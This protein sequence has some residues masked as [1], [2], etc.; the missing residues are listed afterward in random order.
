MGEIKR[1]RS[2][3]RIYTKWDKSTKEVKVFSKKQKETEKQQNINLP[4]DE[5]NVNVSNMFAI[6]YNH[7]EFF[8]DFFNLTGDKAKLRSRIIMS[9]L[10][11]KRFYKALHENFHKYN[12]KYE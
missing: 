9:P 2:G 12:K 7:G 8:L 4:E 3:K 6:G 11:M 10:N 5:I 1:Y